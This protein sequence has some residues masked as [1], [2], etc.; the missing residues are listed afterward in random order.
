MVKGT[1][2]GL[3]GEGQGFLP[4]TCTLPHLFH[5]ATLMGEVAMVRPRLVLAAFSSYLC[6]TV[7]LWTHYFFSLGLTLPLRHGES[8]SRATSVEIGTA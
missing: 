3:A 4:A 6:M 5:E 1:S 7:S 8:C 2:T